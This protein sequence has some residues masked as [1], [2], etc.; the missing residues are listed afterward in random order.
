MRCPV[1]RVSPQIPIRLK[2]P[3]FSYVLGFSENNIP[4][5]HKHCRDC[6]QQQDIAYYYID[7]RG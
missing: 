5:K 3:P 1:F 4:D 2:N 7:S 6:G